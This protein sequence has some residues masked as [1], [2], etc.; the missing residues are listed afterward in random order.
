MRRSLLC[1]SF[2][3]LAPAASL[4]LAAAETLAIKAGRIIPVSQEPIDNGVILIRDGKIEAVGSGLEIP[5]DAKV[6][7]ATGKVVI[8]GLID[9]HNASGMSQANE[10][11][12]NVPFLSVVDSID[13]AQAYFEECRRNGVTTAAVVPGNSTMIGG[14][15]AIVKTAGTYVD[16]MLLKRHAGMKISLVPTQGSRM[17]HLARLRAQFDRAKQAAAGETPPETPPP[18]DSPPPAE[19][20]PPPGGPP[21]PPAGENQGSTAEDTA[22]GLEAL[23]RLLK[24]EMNAFVYCET[25]ADVSQALRLISDYKFKA[26]LVLGPDCDKAARELG[27]ARVPVIL[28]SSLVYWR[29]DPRTRKDEKVVMPRVML[30]HNVEFIFQAELSGNRQTVGG[31]YL[32]F[33]AATAIKHGM[34]RDDAIRALTLRPA[35]WLGVAEFVGSIEPGKDADLV[36]LTGDP[37]KLDTW[38]DATII[39][40]D[41]IYD[42]SKDEKLKPLLQAGGE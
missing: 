39:E 38:V 29:T 12:P 11:N 42:R 6:I 22:A 14:Q 23:G 25:S 16:E 18:A 41:V 31:N 27:A 26:L 8:P 36:V 24:G 10:R 37:L 1:F 28:D 30:D 13:P 15:A 33:Q 3:L 21:Q 17:S 9:A 32:W 5:V 34:S 19:G 2:L 35:Q 4:P 20:Q 7:D 40:G